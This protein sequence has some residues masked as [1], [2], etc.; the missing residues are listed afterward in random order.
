MRGMDVTV[1]RPEGFALP[2]P[3]MDKARRAAATYGG[4]VRETADRR[5]ALAGAQVIYAKEWG[6]TECYGDAE[7]D[8]RLRASLGDWCV[9]DSWFETTDPA[10]RLMHCLPVRRNTAVADEVLDGPR[11]IVQ[12]E[13]HNRLIVQMA[14]LYPDAQ[15]RPAVIMHRTD[16]AAAIRALKSAAPYIRMY[17]GKTFVVKAGGGGF[18]QSR[19]DPL[20]HRT[21]Q[22]P[23]LHG[24][25]RG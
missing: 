4:S 21:D 6:A 13:A 25:A 20:A 10:C 14:V 1:L 2:A 7:A 15:R 22:H 23:A 9:R 19:A 12:R 11:S 5:E 8:A 24:R 17:K 18:R 3:I 16:Q